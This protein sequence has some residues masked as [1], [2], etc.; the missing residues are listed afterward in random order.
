[1]VN[2][3]QEAELIWVNQLISL[4]VASSIKVDELFIPYLPYAR[5]DKAV[6]NTVTFAKQIFLSMLFINKVGKVT[7]LDQHSPSKKISSY[8]PTRYI[9]QAINAFS[10]DALVFPD[11]SAYSRY[12][13]IMDVSKFEIIVLDKVREQTSGLI[14]GLTLD[15]KNTSP[16][17]VKGNKSKSLNM[18]MIDDICDGGATFINAAEY[19]QTHYQCQLALYVTH[20][21]F[22][23]GTEPL[24]KAG[25]TSLF[26]TQSLIKNVSGYTL[27][28]FENDI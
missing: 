18:L 3:E 11:A 4:L 9:Q 13:Q 23:K 22:S 16:G 1:M 20:G 7:T 2:T 17:L 14:S 24:I 8:A 5:Q 25:I 27:K 19:L 10:P 21:I 26:T 12:A 28:E 6:G 15:I